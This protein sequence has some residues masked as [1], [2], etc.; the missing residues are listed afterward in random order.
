MAINTGHIETVFTLLRVSQ[1]VLAKANAP[2]LQL[3]SV[4]GWQINESIIII[5]HILL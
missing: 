3:I 4:S 1:V 2:A 5:P